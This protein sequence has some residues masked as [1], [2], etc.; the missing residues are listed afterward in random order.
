MPRPADGTRP[1]TLSTRAA[2]P[3]IAPRAIGFIA[4][5]ALLQIGILF[6]ILPSRLHVHE[7][8]IASQTIRAP[9]E[10]SYNSDVLRHQLQDQA[11]RNVPT[12]FSYDVNVKND[13][14]AKLSDLIGRITAARNDP[15]L[16]RSQLVDALNNKGALLSPEQRTAIAGFS[17]DD[18][19]QTTD[20]A[21]RLLGSVLEDGFVS[22]DLNSRLASLPNRVSVG[23]TA[24]SG[25]IAVALARGLIVPTERL[26]SAATQRDQDQAA[27]SVPP[28]RQTFAK[29]QVIVRDGDVIDG[30]KREALQNAGLLTVRLRYNDL[31]AVAILSLVASCALAAFLLG[32]RPDVLR[33]TSRAL[34]LTLIVA[35]IIAL[36]KIYMPLVLPDSRRQF[37]PFAFP[38]AAVAMLITSLFDAGLALAAGGITALLV[39]FTALYLPDLSGVVGLTALQPLEMTSAFFFGGLAGTLCVNRAER[40]NRFL[41]AGV[42]VAAATL[43]VLFGFWLLDSARHAGDLGYLV[44]ASAINGVISALLTVATFVLLGTVFNVSTRLQ[45]MELG[46]LNQPLLRRLQEEAPG[47]FHHSILV[48]NLGE[49]AADLIGADALL[50]RVGCYYHD[51]GKLSRPGFY[52]E[53]QL[54]GTNPHDSLD[55]ITSNNIV[56]EHVR[57]GAE[58]SKKHRLP[59]R[60]RDFTV[61]H[62]GTRLVAYFY[63]R[64]AADNPDIDP[65]IFTYPGPR[66][67]SKETAIAMLSDSTEAVVRSSRDHSAE[68]IDEL[69]EGVI[70]ERLSEGQFDDCELTLRDLRTIADS[71]KTTLRAIYHPRIEYP[72]PTAV[73]RERH[74]RRGRLHSQPALAPASEPATAAHPAAAAEEADEIAVPPDE[75]VS[76]VQ[77]PEARDEE[78]EPQAPAASQ[79]EGSEHEDLAAVPF[80]GLAKRH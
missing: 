8:D 2:A 23:L 15:T 32:F 14:L 38:A 37:L 68:K 69:V 24:T 43:A 74:S 10:F 61:E 40:F 25:D 62:H 67:Q 53:N 20:E 22:T 35:G 7:G 64:A 77:P 27:A 71:F 26:D 60:V 11:I 33:T 36:A 75:S 73:E 39:T 50:V 55:P 51:I 31:A 47:T 17:N 80:P 28:Q 30:F 57:Y 63:R 3:R 66:P 59:D 45:L 18:W 12:S 13:Q 79:E 52:I 76:T 29:N 21:T 70:A 42:A 1:V 34:L 72:E 49:R 41:S 46:Q 9:R 4:L 54:G 65:A 78:P 5:L 58:L 16:S 44:L 6:P 19:R 56:Q 48:G